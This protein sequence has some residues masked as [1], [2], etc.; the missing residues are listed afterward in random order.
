MTVLAL[1]AG[2]AAG[3]GLGG[4]VDAVRRS[5]PDGKGSAEAARAWQQLARADVGELPALLAGMDGANPVARNWLRSAVGQVV[6]RAEA[7]KQP[8]PARDLEAFLADRRHDRLAR[9][10]AY[11]LVCRADKSA[12]QRL[13]PTFLD[14]PS[15]D[16]RR[17]AVARELEQAEAAY[18][19]GKKDESVPLYRKALDAALEKGQID[20]AA[21][22]LRE[23]KQP[24][25]VPA[26]LGLIL[27]WKIVGPF[28]NE[29]QKG[30]DTVYPPEE[31]LDFSATYPGKAG[32]VRWVDY[33]SKSEYGAVDL[34][35]GLAEFL[36]KKDGKEELFQEAVAYAA[37]EFTAKE[38]RDV[39]IRL[40]CF[41]GFKLWVNGELVLARGD[42]YAGMRLDHY[43]ARARLKAGKNTIL[44]K[45]AL[46]VPPPPQA[47]FAQM[48]FLLRVCDDTGKAVLST[49][50]PPAPQPE[51]K[52][53]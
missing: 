37:A 24:V 12:A 18:K 20:A 21:K 26:H 19:A 6:E 34:K 2:A 33:A 15:P 32:T 42:A 44:L 9:R 41:T 36:P 16:L 1:A 40:G 43:V 7:D 35:A 22:R 5:G 31:K 29:K 23:L 38:D 50:R 3:E 39:E 28:S 47:Q 45:A 25:D 51:K 17:E 13:L 27:D 4:A 52:P 14:D 8:L 10:L 53:S 11:E 30:I 48:R 49:T 46:D